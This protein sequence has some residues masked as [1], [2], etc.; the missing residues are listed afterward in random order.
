MDMQSGNRQRMI[1]ALAVMNDGDDAADLAKFMSEGDGAAYS[2]LIEAYS[3][4]PDRELS[5]RRVIK[6]LVSSEQFSS[7]SEVHPAWILEHLREETPRVIGII[8]RFLP[9]RHVRYL[10]KNLPPMLCEQVPNMV[11]S[12]SVSPDILNV[13]RKRFEKHFLPMRISRFVE[14]PG[15]DNLYYLKE[16]ELDEV[17]RDVGLTEMAIALSA[18]PSKALHVVYNRLDVRDAKRLQSRI[19]EL[20]NVSPELFRQARSTLLEIESERVGPKQLLKIIGLSVFA[21]AVD[22]GDRNLVR[23]IQQKL[24]PKDGYLL[25]RFVDA[26]RVRPSPVP[27]DDRQGM[28][29]ESVT[30]LAREGRIAEAWGHSPPADEVN[31]NDEAPVPG[32]FGDDETNTAHLLA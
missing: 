28:I 19:R 1:S 3:G 15:F 14:N 16:S 7:L 26:R 11:E 24:D 12:F 5:M 4:E 2:S 29:L 18:M 27:R 9:S 23:M 30:L 31:P 21:D 20:S 10:L 25:K 32:G 8:L 17:F 6:H 22:A 13:I